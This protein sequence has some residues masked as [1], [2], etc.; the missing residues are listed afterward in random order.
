MSDKPELRWFD[1][2]R[3]EVGG[4]L[5]DILDDPSAAVD[6]QREALHLRKTRELIES[7][8]A[9]VDEV[10][11][12]RIFELGICQGGS[13]ALLEL[14]ARPDRHVAVELASG[15]PALDA[16]LLE[17]RLTDTVR[18]Y[19]GTD[20]ADAAALHDIVARDFGGEPLDLVID[21]AS[22][23]FEQTRVSFNALFP[24]VRPGGL[25]VIEDWSWVH[26]LESTIL[27]IAERD[28]ETS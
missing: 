3:V 6:G 2:S 1:D 15:A 5:F 11:P 13:V 8:Q 12:R 24:Y 21:D 16:W 18:T 17:Q 20:Q 9:I 22:H 26:L 14:L 10:G 27:A 4:V 7:L 28:V 19:Y 23:L 25:Y